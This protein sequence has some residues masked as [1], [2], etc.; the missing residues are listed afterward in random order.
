MFFLMI[1]KTQQ[2]L[3]WMKGTEGETSCPV[4]TGQR[5]AHKNRQC[6]HT[7][8][9][10]Y[11]RKAVAEEELRGGVRGRERVKENKENS[12]L[13]RPFIQV[14]IRKTNGLSPEGE[15]TCGRC[16]DNYNNILKNICSSNLEKLHLKC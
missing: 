11:F 9:D 3:S 7:S 5:H 2:I 1:P 13:I 6:Y 4:E 12:V 15:Q 14:S 8:E 16:L 10:L